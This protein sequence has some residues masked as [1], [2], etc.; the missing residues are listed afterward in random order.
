M[1]Y[2][3]GCKMPMEDWDKLNRVDC[4]EDT[5][6][7]KYVGPFPSTNLMEN[8]S[9]LTNEQDFASHGA[10]FFVALSQASPKPL[11]QYRSLLDF[12]CGCGRFARMLKG[13]PGKIS[14]CDIDGR[15]VEWINQNLPYMD[16]K[17]SKVY[18]PVPFEENEFEAIV[19][20]SIFTHLTE[21]SQ[22]EFLGELYRICSPNGI[23]F[24]TVHGEQ[25]FTRA[26]NETPIWDM[27]SVDQALFDNAAEQFLDGKHM[28]IRQEGH[29]TV[30]D[31][32]NDLSKVISDP[33]EYGIAFTPEL[34]IRSH[35]TNWFDVI[36][37]KSGGIHDFQDIV[38]LT[39]K[40]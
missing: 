26:K 39:P 22:D 16:A 4:F 27:L 40:K 34:Y 15:H 33:F 11:Y 9:G 31:N 23:L 5:S 12:G 7:I 14:G 36:N 29:L 6:L 13:H 21:K 8:V 19:S 18:P 25:A 30:E 1:E 38:V 35:W 20:I 3:L 37:Y 28:F 10:D 17:T 32:S 2:E 24:L